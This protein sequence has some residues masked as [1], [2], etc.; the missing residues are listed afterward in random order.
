[1]MLADLI[2][3]I[4]ST[5]GMDIPEDPNNNNYGHGTNTTNSMTNI[6][7]AINPSLPSNSTNPDI[8]KILSGYPV[9]LDTIKRALET[10]ELECNKLQ[11]VMLD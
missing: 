8:I 9:S 4:N 6:T 5:F 1:V 10:E 11:R 3:Q 7:H 2:S